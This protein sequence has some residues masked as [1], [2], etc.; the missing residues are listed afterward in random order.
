MTHSLVCLILVIIIIL[1]CLGVVA[2]FI[3]ALFG[4]PSLDLLMYAFF[5]VW[6]AGA[7]LSII[8]D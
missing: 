4:Y 8:G 2:A 1:G 5:D 7:I 6:V 3:A